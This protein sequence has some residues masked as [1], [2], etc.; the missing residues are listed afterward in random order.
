MPPPI[1]QP[2]V[3]VPDVLELELLELPVPDVPELPVPEVPE[4]LVPELP[5]PDELPDALPSLAVLPPH[6][7]E[8]TGAIAPAINAETMCM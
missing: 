3:P 5:V 2:P 6:D 7:A 1:E 4:L 8:R